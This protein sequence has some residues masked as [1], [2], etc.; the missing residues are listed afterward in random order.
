MRDRPGVLT[1]PAEQSE[2][3]RIRLRNRVDAAV[4][5][6]VH[7]GDTQAEGNFA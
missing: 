3:W 2:F 6:G 7:A 1:L 5:P 4:N